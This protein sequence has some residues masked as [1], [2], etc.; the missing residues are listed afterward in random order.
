MSRLIASILLSILLF[1]LAALVYLVLFFVLESYRTFNVQEWSA[2]LFAGA[3]TWAFM[4]WYWVFVWR[5]TVHWNPA[6]RARTA[7]AA[8]A[9]AAAA[10]VLGCLI[11]VS[12]DDDF[13][14]FIGSVAAPLLWLVASVLV[15]RETDAERAARLRSQSLRGEGPA[16]P[17]PTC[18][19]DMTGLKGTR[20]PECGSEFTIDELLAAL[21]GRAG[22]ELE[23]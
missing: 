12:L 8:L 9:S 20:C 22:V 3:A 13:G 4:A 2:C 7:Y 11:G 6:R 17:C 14:F 5:R 16:V 1:P 15:W 23:R 10:A 19:Y 18:G 21:P